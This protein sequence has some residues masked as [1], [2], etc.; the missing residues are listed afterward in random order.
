MRPD[1]KRFRGFG[2]VALIH[3][4]K[5]STWEEHKYIKR[6][7]GTYYYPDSYEGG[8]HLSSLKTDNVDSDNNDSTSDSETKKLSDSDVESLALEV[9][10][11][12]FGNG[13][14]RKELLNEYYQQVQNRVNELMRGS[15]GSTKVSNVSESRSLEEKVNEIVEKST[16]AVS[17][18]KPESSSGST[19]TNKGLDYET[20][21]GVYRK[22]S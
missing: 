9:I 12:N 22:K 20:I 2:L 16:E 10:R 17:K 3:S 6:I 1:F 19:S 18:S 14:V 4:A 15:T 13:E 7:D 8:R 21:F 5:G 11:G